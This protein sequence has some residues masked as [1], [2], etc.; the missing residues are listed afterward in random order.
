MGVGDGHLP[1]T[2]M[3]RQ[4]SEKL[5]DGEWNDDFQIVDPILIE[6]VRW[7]NFPYPRAQ[8]DN[9]ESRRTID[10]NRISGMLSVQILSNCASV[11]V[12]GNGKSLSSSL[13]ITLPTADVPE[14]NQRFVVSRVVG[15]LH[16]LYQTKHRDAIC[17]HSNSNESRRKPMGEVYQ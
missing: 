11:T 13:T 16:L 4:L 7:W 5:A 15:R 6:I 14:C 10:A 8:S 9:G 3:R 2:H 1:E 12:S 17:K